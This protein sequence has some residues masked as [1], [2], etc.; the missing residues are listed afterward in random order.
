[1]SWKSTGILL[2]W[3]IFKVKDHI[4]DYRSLKGV[5]GLLVDIESHKWRREYNQENDIPPD[6]P[7]ASNS[8]D[9]ECLFSV[10]RDMVRKDFTHKEV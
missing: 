2:F 3:L 5:R 1:M 8:D 6:L 10:L 4:H 9:V 7:R